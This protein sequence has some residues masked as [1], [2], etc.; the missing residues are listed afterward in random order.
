MWAL[1]DAVAAC[2]YYKNPQKAKE[3][4]ERLAKEVNNACDTGLLP[5]RTGK[6]VTLASP[7]SKEYIAPTLKNI[8]KA[9]LCVIKYEQIYYDKKYL[10]VDDET[11]SKVRE[12][13]FYL[14]QLSHCSRSLVVING[15]AFDTSGDI[16]IK[17]FDNLNKQVNANII[18]NDSID[19]YNHFDKKYK[20]A[21][22]ARFSVNYVFNSKLDYY[23]NITN[24]SGE[25]IK[26]LINNELHGGSNSTNI[27]SHIDNVS[28]YNK[29]NNTKVERAKNIFS[30]FL[31]VIYRKTNPI[32]TIIALLSLLILT[33][34]TFYKL[35]KKTEIYY[36]KEVI[37]LWGLLLA[38]FVRTVMIAYVSAS[39][40]P[41]IYLLYLSSSYPVMIIFNCMS[42][43]CLFSFIKK[44][45]KIKK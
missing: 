4:Y 43:C 25:K 39:S 15:W 12:M 30:N 23:L 10:F 3:Y 28:F 1:R 32:I 11:F 27:I 16:D 38:F 31:L 6:R 20:T 40:F 13:E 34:S 33:F 45:I 26:L 14:N 36:Y 42:I 24:K 44:Y 7:F 21:L 41:A 5:S 35:I 8:K 17:I 19:V 9:A 2:G 37:I 18:L 22:K 29:E